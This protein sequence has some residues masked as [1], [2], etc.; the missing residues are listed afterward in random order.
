MSTYK[1]R[2]DAAKTEYV[3]TDGVAEGGVRLWWCVKQVGHSWTN[4]DVENL[5][6]LFPKLTKETPFPFGKDWAYIIGHVSQFFIVPTI[7]LQFLA[8][9]KAK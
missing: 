4:M 7:V 8:L 3:S 9:R 5:R 6:Y 2:L 1:E